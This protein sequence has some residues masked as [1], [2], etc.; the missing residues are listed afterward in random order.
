MRERVTFERERERESRSRERKIERDEAR[1]TFFLGH[2]LIELGDVFIA[3][4][5]D[6]LGSDEDGHL[7]GLLRLLRLLGFIRV[8]RPCL[9]GSNKD[10]HLR[11]PL[12]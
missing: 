10:T 9:L 6:L 4:S 12:P 7:Q 5:E 1:G 11:G 8:I 2:L 3:R